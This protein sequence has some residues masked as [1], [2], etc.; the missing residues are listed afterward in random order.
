MGKEVKIGLAVMGAL[1]CTF[2]GVLLWRLRPEKPT[3]VAVAKS[4]K[5]QQTGKKPRQKAA[6]KISP[7]KH[8]PAFGSTSHRS[9]DDGFGADDRDGDL[10]TADG[11]V[12]NDLASKGR[13]NA[14]S[15]SEVEPASDDVPD[16]A[17]SPYGDRYRRNAFEEDRVWSADSSPDAATEANGSDASVADDVEMPEDRFAGGAEQNWADQTEVVADDDGPRQPGLSFD[18]YGVDRYGERSDYRLAPLAAEDPDVR[19][20]GGADADGDYPPADEVSPET[21]DDAGEDFATDAAPPRRLTGA[22]DETYTVEANDNFWIISQKTYGTGA[23]HRAL[24]AHN[25]QQNGGAAGLTAGEQI[26]TPPAE[27]LRDE[28]P[29]FC[30]KPRNVPTPENIALAG[31]TRERSPRIYT[32]ADGDTLFD[33]ARHELGK[34]S[35]WLEIYEL[36]RDQ[37]G[38]DFRDLAPGMQLALPGDRIGPIASRP[39]PD[40][41]RR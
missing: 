12:S 1:L 30:P 38:E 35:R 4:E 16:V 37:L 18:R 24:E 40:L 10:A 25:R 33:I 5:A 34:A 28:Y 29:Q 19:P 31:S 23:Y 14:W 7:G 11:G 17:D 2:G 36:N 20:A 9:T 39:R 21:T 6:A 22:G 13:E 27:L 26:S 32:V 15:N 41:Y 8:P 3:D